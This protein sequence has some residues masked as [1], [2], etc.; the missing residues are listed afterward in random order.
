MRAVIGVKLYMVLMAMVAC[1]IGLCHA[2]DVKASINVIFDTDMWSTLTML[3]R[4]PCSI[5]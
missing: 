1:T 4:W 2:A 5:G 3:W